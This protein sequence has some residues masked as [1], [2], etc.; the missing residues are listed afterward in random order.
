MDPFLQF[1]LQKHM[2]THQKAV[3]QAPVPAADSPV[4]GLTL[5]PGHPTPFI[6]KIL[7][8]S[9]QRSLVLKSDPEEREFPAG[10]A[11]KAAVAKPSRK[12]NASE[13]L[14]ATE[15]AMG[16]KGS[17]EKGRLIGA[18][19]LSQRHRFSLDSSSPAVVVVASEVKPSLELSNLPLVGSVAGRGGLLQVKSEPADSGV[20]AEN[21]YRRDRPPLEKFEAR[22]NEQQ[23]STGSLILV[24]LSSPRVF[25]AASPP[26]ASGAGSENLLSCSDDSPTRWVVKKEAEMGGGQAASLSRT[27]SSLLSEKEDNVGDVE[28]RKSDNVASLPSSRLVMKNQVSEIPDGA[29]T[30]QNLAVAIDTPVINNTHFPGSNETCISDAGEAFDSA[31]ATSQTFLSIVKP[32]KLLASTA[33]IFPLKP[34]T[35]PLT[36]N[37]CHHYMEDI[38]LIREHLKRPHDFLCTFCPRRFP[39]ASERSYHLSSA[40]PERAL[41]GQNK[42]CPLCED[43]IMTVSYKK[44]IQALHKIACSMC[45]CSFTQ[46]NRL[47]SHMSKRHSN[48]ASA[49]GC[50]VSAVIPLRQKGRKVWKQGKTGT[51]KGDFARQ[52]LSHRAS[53]SA[54]YEVNIIGLFK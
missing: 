48:L 12:R 17:L 11:P 9:L 18:Q 31:A 23:R 38:R 22:K 49:D 25:S 51:K 16:K 42:A 24:R 26:P 46:K 27:P 19:R 30:V 40:H 20:S 29:E 39:A 14:A 28:G 36:C 15:A 37:L 8:Q 45:S 13:G 4:I 10:H 7:K 47:V 2:I 1:K 44:H 5:Q 43:L 6:P 21:L 52:R 35:T 41:P 50:D 34:L 53:S 32:G 3:H 54:V 33:T